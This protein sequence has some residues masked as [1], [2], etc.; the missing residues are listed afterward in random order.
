MPHAAP[1]NQKVLGYYRECRKN[2]NP[3]CDVR[4]LF[5]SNHSI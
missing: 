3:F 4:L 2:I 1:Q 5:G